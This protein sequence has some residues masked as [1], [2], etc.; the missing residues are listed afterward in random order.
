M[1]TFHHINIFRCIKSSSPFQPALR[2]CR[3]TWR[4]GA[5][6]AL[7]FGCLTLDLWK[8][9]RNI[10]FILVGHSKHGWTRLGQND[11]LALGKLTKAILPF[12]QWV[13]QSRSM[14]REPLA[15]GPKK[16][17]L[18]KLRV[19]NHQALQNQPQCLKIPCFAKGKFNKRKTHPN[20]HLRR[21]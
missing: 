14:K 21:T 7:D 5:R 9:L 12:M 4:L 8:T 2:S 17:P 15:K 18:A 19:E 16:H 13:L 10:P 1:P 11:P 6:H 20:H 3:I